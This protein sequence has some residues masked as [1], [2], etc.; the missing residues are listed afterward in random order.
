MSLSKQSLLNSLI[1]THCGYKGGYS[2]KNNLNSASLEITASWI[3]KGTITNKVEKINDGGDEI[4]IPGNAYENGYLSSTEIINILAGLNSLF[5]DVKVSE[6]SNFNALNLNNIN[7]AMTYVSIRKERY[8][9][10]IIK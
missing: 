3:F 5:G 4:V 9:Y 10:D 2:N 8:S 1:L 7:S 6:V